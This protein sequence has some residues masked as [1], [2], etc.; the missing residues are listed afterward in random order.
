M[1]FYQLCGLSLLAAALAMLL[2]AASVKHAPLLSLCGGSLLLLFALDRYKT[3]IRAM[4]EM[5]E[6]AGISASVEVVLRMLALGMLSSFAADLCREMGEP[7]LAA[8]V[9]LCGRAEILLLCLPFLDEL[10]SLAIG[11]VS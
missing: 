3:P 5:A 11:L 6:E 7:T 1:S 9:E 4:M 8:R 10:F 2:R